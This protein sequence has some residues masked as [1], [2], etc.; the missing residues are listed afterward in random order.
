MDI[1]EVAKKY[2]LESDLENIPLLRSDFVKI[3]AKLH[4]DKNG[5]NFKD[6]AEKKQFE[7]IKEALDYL[8]NTY[9]KSL[10]PIN[11]LTQIIKSVSEAIQ[12]QKEA[13]LIQ[14]KNELR[15]DIKGEIRTRYLNIRISSGVFGGISAA[16]LTFSQTLSDNPVFGSYFKSP[17][18]ISVLGIIF[19]YSS[20]FFVLTWL[21]EQKDERRKEWLFSEE[22]KISLLKIVLKNAHLNDGGSK[23]I[24]SFNDFVNVVKSPRD[25]ISHT[26]SDRTFDI[27]RLFL[28]TRLSISTAEQLAN[29]HLDDLEKRNLVEQLKGKS[30][31]KYYAVDIKLYRELEESV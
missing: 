5:G 19:L 10:I 29:F 11:E 25:F 13:I 8:D 18:L 21:R 12:P 17:I 23:Y 2:S 6:E 28:S 16:L 1:K 27:L 4:P 30:I 14:Q 15:K 26:N 9:S 3:L 20:L 7:E 24:F 31:H 22:G